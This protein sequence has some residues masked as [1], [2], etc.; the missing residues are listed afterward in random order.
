MSGNDCCN[1]LHFNCCR[2]ADNELADLILS[3]SLFQNCAAA[4]MTDKQ[5]FLASDTWKQDA[6][7]MKRVRI[8]DMLNSTV[9]INGLALRMRYLPSSFSTFPPFA[10]FSSASAPWKQARSTWNLRLYHSVQHGHNWRSI[11][12]SAIWS[13]LLEVLG[14]QTLLVITAVDAV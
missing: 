6:A 2:K 14:Y 12:F 11:A 4:T 3:D 13:T 1:R 9:V 5:T 7:L 8:C 10:K